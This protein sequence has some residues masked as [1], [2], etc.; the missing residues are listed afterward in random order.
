VAHEVEAEIGGR[1]VNDEEI[2]Q[3][4]EEAKTD[5]AQQSALEDNRRSG[6]L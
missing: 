2:T 4:K 1:V 3:K 6:K 5:N